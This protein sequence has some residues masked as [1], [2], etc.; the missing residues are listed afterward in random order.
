MLAHS[1]FIL[2]ILAEKMRQIDKSIPRVRICA[3]VYALKEVHAKPDHAFPS[4]A[5]FSKIYN[6]RQIEPSRITKGL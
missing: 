1:T 5:T 3:M 4:K 2:S 6:V